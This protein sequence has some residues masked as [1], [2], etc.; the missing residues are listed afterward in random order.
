MKNI[1]LFILFLP[2]VTVCTAQYNYTHIVVAKNGLNIRIQPTDSAKII[3]KFE[4]GTQIEVIE[5]SN[6]QQTITEGLKIITGNWVKVKINNYYYEAAPQNS[7]GFVFSGF[8]EKKDF[9][10]E[11]LEKRILAYKELDEY[12]IDSDN[13][14]FCLQGYFFDATKNNLAILIKK[15]ESE[16]KIINKNIVFLDVQDSS[17][18]QKPIFYLEKDNL[19]WVGVFMKVKAGTVLWSN[20]DEDWRNFEDVPTSEKVILDYDAI[21]LHVEEGCGGGFIFWKD[22]NFNWLQQE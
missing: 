22:G 11:K 8:L 13:G 12:E 5:S 19:E 6:F 10:V 9:F 21:F 4:F 1:L 18:T 14:I 20:Y 15:K 7:I 2:F 16:N 17:A 3:G